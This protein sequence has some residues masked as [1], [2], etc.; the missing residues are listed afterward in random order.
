MIT[1]RPGHDVV[2]RLLSH[3]DAGATDQADSVFTIPASAYGDATVAANERERVFAGLPLA[4][5]LGADIPAPGDYLVVELPGNELVIVRQVDA[6]VKAFV[7]A[8]RHRGAPVA[9]EAGSCRRFSC[10]YHG[11]TYGLDG[12]LQGLTY[13]KTFGD[14]DTSK[15]GL[16]EVPAT[17]RHG[18]VWVVD[19]PHLSLDLD[20]WLG[21]DM[22]H[23]LADLQFD[24][25]IL[26][27]A[28]GLR[29]ANQLEDNTGRVSRQL[30][31]AISPCRDDRTVRLHQY[32]GGGVVRPARSVHNAAE[33]NGRKA[34]C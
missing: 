16:V 27:S 5:S 26:P 7:N 17:E 31:S 28:P 18:L 4:V 15:L 23:L 19:D 1:S 12:Q 20:A 32:I 8:C 13:L 34:L 11:W 21:S 6:S 30:P 3:V 29:R 2:I 22:D 25:A 33:V 9:S 10:P 24:R 14:V